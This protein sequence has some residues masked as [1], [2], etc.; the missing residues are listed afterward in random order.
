MHIGLRCSPFAGRRPVYLGDDHT[1]APALAA[2]RTAGGIAV[3]VGTRVAPQATHLLPYPDAVR[4]W[5]AQ[6]ARRLPWPVA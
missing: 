1:D 4:A 5:L 2:V 3:A 6:L